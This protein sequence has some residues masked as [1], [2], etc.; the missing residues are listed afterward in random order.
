MRH[1]QQPSHPKGLKILVILPN[2]E[3]IANF[4]QHLE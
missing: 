1:L 2:S 4:V 3:R